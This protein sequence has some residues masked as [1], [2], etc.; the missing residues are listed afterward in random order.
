MNKICFRRKC[1]Y[2]FLSTIALIFLCV[3]LTGCSD[4]QTFSSRIQQLD[5][6]FEY[7]RGWR[8][9]IIEQY[10]DLVYANLT[11]PDVSEN[12]SAAKADFTVHLLKGE[13]E[14]Q[15]A[16]RISNESYYTDKNSRNFN[17]IRQEITGI[18]SYNGYL[19]EYTF[20]YTTLP[21]GPDT[22]SYIPSR[23]LDIAVPRNGMVYEIWISASQ[24]EWNAREQDIQ[25][26]LSTF[27]WK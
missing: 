9:D 17:I 18:D 8:V 2:L 5:F 26:I 19:V 25:H 3:L 27:K 4:Y 22:W 12:E 11:G 6:T 14:G 16:Q 15:A 1:T 20:D 23:I 7:P 10:S 21:T 24:N 13:Q